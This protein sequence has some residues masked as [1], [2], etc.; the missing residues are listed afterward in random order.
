MTDEKVDLLGE[1]RKMK[2][3]ASATFF[4]HEGKVLASTIATDPEEIKYVSASARARAA[5][6]CVDTLNALFR[7]CFAMQRV[8]DGI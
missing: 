7:C 4:D 3:W 1:V 5:L 6:T 8:I 2:E